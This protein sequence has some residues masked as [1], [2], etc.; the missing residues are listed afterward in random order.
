M[1]GLKTEGMTGTEISN[2]GKLSFSFPLSVFGFIFFFPCQSQKGSESWSRTPKTRGSG[3]PT[4]A[5]SCDLIT[6]P[7][8]SF[9]LP[10]NLVQTQLPGLPVQWQ[11][12]CSLLFHMGIWTLGASFCCWFCLFACFFKETETWLVL[13]NPFLAL[14]NHNWLTMMSLDK[15]QHAFPWSWTIFP[16]HH[17]F[18]FPP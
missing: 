11:R 8:P 16:V 5:G 1:D 7:D 17:Y 9:F 3:K 10:G 4:Q 6:G 2:L 12:F 15:G 18:F 13:T 14:G